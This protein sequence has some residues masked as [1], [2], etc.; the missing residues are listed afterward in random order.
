MTMPRVAQY[1]ADSA[2]LRC[3]GVRRYGF[4]GLSYAYLMEELARLADRK[5]HEVASS[6]RTSAT[7]RVW[8]P[9]DDGKSM[10]TSMGFTPTAGCADEH[11]LRRSRSRLGLVPGAN[12]K[13]HPEK[14]NEMVNFE[15]GLLGISETSSDMQDL[16]ERETAGR[17]GSRGGCACFATR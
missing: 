1:I 11:P 7:A 3:A 8:R 17:A 14:F 4:H 5:R 2:P 9:C 16:L 10:D 12:R 15:S 6:S 13:Y